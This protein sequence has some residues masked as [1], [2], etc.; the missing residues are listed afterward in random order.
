MINVLPTGWR[1]G[2]FDDERDDDREKRGLME[3]DAQ[4]GEG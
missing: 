4:R 1:D 3:G 2:E